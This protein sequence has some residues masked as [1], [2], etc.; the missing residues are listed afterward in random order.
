MEADECPCPQCQAAREIS[1]GSES[2]AIKPCPCC[3]ADA[4]L[5]PFAVPKAIRFY[6]Q[7]EHCGLRTALISTESEA[8]TLWNCRFME[9]PKA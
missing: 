2:E 7:C 4:H 9:G 3:G 6:V 8:V 5:V 1:L